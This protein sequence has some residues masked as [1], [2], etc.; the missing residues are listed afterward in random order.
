LSQL[1]GEALHRDPYYNPNFDRA[2]AD[3]RLPAFLRGDVTTDAA[4]PLASG[5][6][7]AGRESCPSGD[8][9]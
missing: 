7:K 4:A 9:R 2:F 1:W 6:G 8:S 3:Y 5:A